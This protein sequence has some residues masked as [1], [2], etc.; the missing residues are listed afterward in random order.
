MSAADYSSRSRE[1]RQRLLSP[2]PACS[3]RKV[4]ESI[5]QIQAAGADLEPLQQLQLWQARGEGVIRKGSQASTRAR[6]A[7]SSAGVS[8]RRFQNPAQVAS[9]REHRV[10]VCRAEQS[11]P[12]WFDDIGVQEE[13]LP[14]VGSGCGVCSFERCG[15]HHCEQLLEG[16]SDSLCRC[17]FVSLCLCASGCP[18]VCVSVSRF[19]LVCVRVCLYLCVYVCACTCAHACTMCAH[20]LSDCVC[21]CW[22]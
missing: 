22:L 5:A 12:P 21:V 16:L 14:L 19:L 11:V 13:E 9:Q 3:C 20:A 4:G 15:Q 8:Q 6:F 10:C 1:H 18:C 7:P 2:S 17:V